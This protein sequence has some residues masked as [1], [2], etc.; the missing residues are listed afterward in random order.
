MAR[1]KLSRAAAD[2]AGSIISVAPRQSLVTGWHRYEPIQSAQHSVQESVLK[3]PA[4]LARA[5]T[6]RVECTLTLRGGRCALGL[7][8]LLLQACAFRGPGGGFLREESFARMP[9]APPE[10]ARLNDSGAV[11]GQSGFRI[12]S[13][14]LDGLLARIEVIDTARDTL[15]LQYFLFRGDESGLTVAAALLRAADRG[16]RIRVI[17][18]DGDTVR[19]DE[20]LLALA[21]HP[22]I[23]MRVFNPFRYRGHIKLIKNLEFILN[24]GRLDYR[25]HDKLLVADNTVALIGGRNIGDQYFQIDPESQFGDDDVITAGSIV[26]QLSGVFDEF[27]NNPLAVPARA[28]DSKHTG[29]KGLIEL[30]SAAGAEQLQVNAP[31]SPFSKRFATGEPLA[32]V[33]SGRTPL[34]WAKVGLVYD[35]PNK[36]DIAAGLRAGNQIYQAV[37]DKAGAVGVEMLVITP[38]LIPTPDELE[39]V[40][41]ERSRG[42]RVR[43]LTNSLAS[44]PDLAGQAGYMR[45]RPTFLKEGVELYEIRPMPG[46]AS[47]TGQSMSIS[48]HGNYALHAKL[49][50]FDRK[51]MF[52]GSMNFDQRSR[53]LN[54]EIGLIIESRELAEQTAA[55]FDALTQLDNS[56][57]VERIPGGND[58][59]IGIVWKSRDAGVDKV[60]TTEPARSGW[61]R[62]IVHF[63]ALLPLDSEL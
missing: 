62:F 57:T 16:V 34:V 7:A 46:K 21:A 3:P 19:G 35:S 37:A 17:V 63:L 12:L 11:P 43:I 60:Y 50:V 45:H 18:D 2:P 38:Y 55:R 1:S 59:R 9:N 54:T 8:L 48:R 27:W 56:Y 10:V 49:F 28:I 26:Q 6:F 40:K 58:K 52:I 13:A 32:G 51:S 42:A 20:K 53:R 25:M 44:A 33:T 15:D 36:K 39:L 30:R 5:N 4:T 31:D 24:K 23:E 29:D 14:G 22:K 41:N 47:G 61:Q